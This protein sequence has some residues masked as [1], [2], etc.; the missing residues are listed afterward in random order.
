MSALAPPRPTAG[1][2]G[3]PARR[4]LV[5]WSWRLLRREWR[6][7]ALVAVLLVVTVIAAVCGATTIANLPD[8]ADSRLG[9]ADTVMTLNGKDPQAVASDLAKI[10]ASLGTVEVIGHSSEKAPGLGT[11]VDYR[12]QR[13]HGPFAGALL[14]IHQG[15][16]PQGT[17]EAAIT[18]GLAQLLGLR[19][20]GTISLD[21][22]ARAVVGIAENPSFLADQFVLVDPAS[23]QPQSLSV[24]TK[25]P[26]GPGGLGLT[27]ASP[28][29][30][31]A[32]DNNDGIVVAT[33]VLGC[34]MILLLLVAF[35][36]AAAFA[37]L[38]HRRLRQLGMLAA[39]G[40]TDRQVRQVMTATGLLIGV[41]A[42][43]LGTIGGLALWPLVA[44]RLESTVDHRIAV[45][46]IPWTLIGVLLVLAIVTSTG[47]AWW[48][49]RS[50]SRMPVTLALSGRPPVRTSA[51]RS[52]LLAA[53]LFIAGIGVLAWAG[54][55]RPWPV[56]GATLLTALA[57]LFAAPGA[58]RVLA[59]TGARAPIAVRLALRDLAR[60]PA[61][62]GAAVAA[63]S[64]A[65]GVPAVLV[66]VLTGFQSTPTTGNLGDRQMLVQLSEA[67]DDNLVH[68]QTP[69]EL[70]ALA[71]Q[72]NRLVPGATVVPLTKA[73][74]PDMQKGAEPDGVP[75]QMTV[76]AGT[77]GTGDES[78][79]VSTYVASPA[80]YRLLGADPARIG[81]ATDLVTTRSDRLVIP[82]DAR[83]PAITR[84]QG[85]AYTSMPT[86]LITPAALARHGWT[87]ISSGWFIQSD[88]PL[89]GAQQAA[90]RSFAVNNGLTV[91]IRDGQGAVTNTRLGAV[92][93]GVLFALGVLAMT[94]GLIRSEAAADLRT[95]TATGATPAIR[96]ILTATT[97][98]ALA[99][100]GVILGVGGACLAMVAIYRH[101][102]AVFGRVPIVYP[103]TVVVGTPVLAVLAGWLLAVREP[104]A[105]ARRMGE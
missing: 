39:I 85:P 98:G 62:S 37:V 4:A 44:P 26:V 25:G 76:S 93:V 86:T 17:G 21:G 55:T 33:L 48:P 80:L 13:L 71:G 95:L 12:S 31:G 64:L 84:V 27:T 100:L 3:V 22:H 5:R 49:A 35:V 14:A 90:A 75:A 81:A 20:G 54:K 70:A 94:V 101:D 36:A 96:R 1:R 57:V 63:I 38:A 92:A 30:G 28:T 77:P 16:Y 78:R 73:V 34:A 46:H 7:Q 47:A 99:L 103:I 69:S 61:R 102:L 79:D 53:V 72:V 67:D 52:A 29:S 40:A 74:S 91:E 82:R 68:T 10:R 9:S 58:V 97:A 8:P 56:A 51:H 66:I 105:I 60:H 50:V 24:L 43:V 18:A 23:T 104:A 19:L 32:G 88:R 2:P 6:S 65:L 15:R 42:A 59:M 45:S 87:T 11:P 83:D 89:T 41:L